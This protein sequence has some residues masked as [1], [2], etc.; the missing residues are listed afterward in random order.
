MTRIGAARTVMFAAIVTVVA[1]MGLAAAMV[2]TAVSISARVLPPAPSDCTVTEPAPRANDAPDV[3]DAPA[4]RAGPGAPAP[5]HGYGTGPPAGRIAML[6]GFAHI[7]P[8]VRA[9]NL[10]AT[11]AIN[12]TATP[13][14]SRA[15]VADDYALGQPAIATALGSRLA[16]A[17]YAALGAGEL[18][19]TTAL[20]FG[21]TSMVSVR[22]DTSAAKRYFANRRPFEVAPQSIRRYP[23]ARKDLYDA[24]RGSGSFPSGHATWGYTQAFL[25]AA[26]LPEIGPQVLARG[27]EYGYHRI[28]LGVHYPLDVIG[29]RIYAQA[30]AADMLGDPRVATLLAQ[31]TT[32]LRGALTARVGAPIA[33]VARCQQ[34]Y[35]PTPAALASYR[36]RSTYDLSPTGD[37][38]R[39]LTIPQGAV[40]LIRA[41]HPGRSDA[42]LRDLLERTALPAGYPLDTA[43]ADGGWQ[44]LDIARAWVSE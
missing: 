17:F 42:E 37:A 31:A 38:T 24:V 16:P 35:L 41:A 27:A 9:Q 26:M 32:E 11:V 7:S 13:A 25:I 12:T 15:A 3:T 33:R 36:Q 29:G 14:V 22:T 21:D 34:P 19:R 1:T 8:R 4:A 20:L 2:G 5:T 30:V 39:P 18:P 44:R 43:G 6:D 10:A 23:D 40:A 28:V